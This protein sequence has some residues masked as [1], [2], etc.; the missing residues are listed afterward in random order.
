[1]AM[2]TAIELEAN[3]M[4]VEKAAKKKDTKLSRGGS[5]RENTGEWDWKNHAPTASEP[6]KK[7]FKGK[8][9]VHCKFHKNTQ[10]VLKDGHNGGCRLDPNFV[11]DAEK[12]TPPEKKSQ[13]SK[14]ALQYAHALM[15]AIQHEENGGFSGEGGTDE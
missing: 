15:A 7:I 14:Q 6:K 2:K 10:W 1:M 5:P 9:Y 8:T 13:P 4:E 12:T 11:K 3:Q